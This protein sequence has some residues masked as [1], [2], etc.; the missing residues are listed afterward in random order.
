MTNILVVNGDENEGKLWRNRL[1][2]GDLAVFPECIG[3][4]EMIHILV[5]E[6]VHLVIFSTNLIDD[7]TIDVLHEV[8]VF[9][10]RTK[11][12]MVGR[13]SAGYI[14]PRLPHVALMQ[15]FPRDIHKYLATT[16]NKSSV[17]IPYKKTV[18]QCIRFLLGEHFTAKDEA[19]AMLSH[20]LQNT[21]GY[22]IIGVE[23]HSLDNDVFR[24]L[25][26]LSV[27]LGFLYVLQ[28]SLNE[29]CIVIDKSPSKE[30]SMQSAYN[31]RRALLEKT[32]AI[33]SI[34]VSRMRYNAGELYACRKEAARACAATHMFG[35]NS[36]IHIDY[37]DSNSIEYIYP[38]HKEKR[39]IQATM[40]GNSAYAFR[41][42]DEIFDVFKSSGNLRQGLIN[43][44]I[45]GIIVNLNIAAASRV[46][47]FEKI[48]LDSLSLKKLLTAASID[49][50]YAFLRNGIEDFSSEMEDFSA[51]SKDALFHRLTEIKSKKM[52]SSDTAPSHISIEE[53][54]QSLHSTVGFINA[55]VYCNSKGDIFNFFKER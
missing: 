12:I 43:K 36:I 11:I 26:D 54:A 24:V 25:S 53:L 9:F 6:E 32:D 1:K 7:C 33:F 18:E 5:R 10:S 48:Q 8:L 42:L 40:D 15:E 41:M 14:L 47:A 28:Y 35:Q 51:V 17:E 44:M 31:I 29:I 20:A 22:V 50:A 2:G 4:S 16:P 46:F 23:T 3:I 30:Y 19:A 34:G 13:I 52:I 38:S 39:L 49:E 27:E 21:P 37:L 45:L 55:A